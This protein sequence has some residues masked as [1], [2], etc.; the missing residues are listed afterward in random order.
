[1]KCAGDHSA[2][3]CPRKE[4]SSDVRCV[5]C[6]GSHPA[7]YKG[8]T[9]YKDLLKAEAIHSPCTTAKNSACTA[10]SHLHPNYKAKCQ[11]SHPKRPYPPY[12]SLNCLEGLIETAAVAS[13]AQVSDSSPIL[14]V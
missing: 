8:C 13:H 10:R 11:Q 4:R 9:V 2:S 1:V 14:L 6:D 3:Q 12:Q 5:L 7:N